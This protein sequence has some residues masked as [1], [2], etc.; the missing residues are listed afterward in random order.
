MYML[1]NQTLPLCSRDNVITCQHTLLGDRLVLATE[2][3]SSDKVEEE[4]R[5]ETLFNLEVTLLAF[6]SD[7]DKLFFGVMSLK[8]S[9]TQ[10]RPTISHF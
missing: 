7:T 3:H 10:E 6:G 4:V 2:E 5:T 1:L 9:G 8:P